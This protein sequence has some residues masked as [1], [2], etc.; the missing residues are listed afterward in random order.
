MDRVLQ[1][2]GIVRKRIDI[3]SIWIDSQPYGIHLLC[4]SPRN[5][6]AQ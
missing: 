5:L 1:W 4:P 6:I 3:L 2:E